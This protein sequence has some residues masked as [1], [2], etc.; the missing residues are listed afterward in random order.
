[1]AKAIRVSI[2][3]QEFDCYAC[4]QGCNIVS[5]NIWEIT[6]PQRKIFRSKYRDTKYFFLDDYDSIAS[7]IYNQVEE[8]LQ[9]Q[10]QENARINKWKDFEKELKNFSKTY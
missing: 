1:M 3:N 6:H 10:A 5:V 7:G 8:Y 4:S 2:N 9:E